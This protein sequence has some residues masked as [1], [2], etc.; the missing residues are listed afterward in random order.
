MG[1]WKLNIVRVPELIYADN[2][3]ITVSNAKSLQKN[4]ITYKQELGKINMPVNI[5]TTK[6]MAIRNKKDN[7]TIKLEE[8]IL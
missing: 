2:I 7:H 4:L 1:K 6:T 5:G 8:Q 3:A